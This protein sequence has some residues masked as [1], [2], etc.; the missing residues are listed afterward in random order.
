[1]KYFCVG[2]HCCD[3]VRKHKRGRSLDK[4]FALLASELQSIVAGRGA[5]SSPAEAQEGG[6]RE[7]E[8][9]GDLLSQ[10][11][12]F[13]PSG[14]PACGMVWPTSRADLWGNPP[15]QTHPEVGAANLLG[16]SQL[17]HTASC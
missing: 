1:M 2:S 17:S 7:R 16:G 4:G 10:S 12:S 8:T 9:C 5:S 14:P 11:P 13:I 15:S 6:G 3:K